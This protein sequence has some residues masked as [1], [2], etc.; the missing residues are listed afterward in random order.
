[1]AGNSANYLFEYTYIC[2]IT[3]YNYTDLVFL[4]LIFIIV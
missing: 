3:L 1:M 4:K 2:R